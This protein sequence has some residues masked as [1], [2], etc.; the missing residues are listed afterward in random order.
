MKRRTQLFIPAIALA[1]TASIAAAQAAS[2]QT[3]SVPRPAQTSAPRA[4]E[5]ATTTLVGCLYR[6][7]QVPGRSPNAAERAGVLEDYIL[8][9][10]QLAGAQTSQARPGETPSA[11]G[12][13]GTVPTTGNMY[14]VEK[15]PDE[16]LKALLGKRVEVI[17]RIDAEH[18]KGDKPGAPPTA[19]RS[20]GPDRMN[21]P[22]F[23]ASSIREVSGSCPATPA[24][25]K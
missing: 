17:G 5:Q 9:D 20:T 3:A 14:K 10:A 18:G 12:T 6:E 23:E 1:S 19:D 11:T 2:G 22:E 16:R 4:S 25:R 21:L 7:E 24:P 8:A 13:S 15:L